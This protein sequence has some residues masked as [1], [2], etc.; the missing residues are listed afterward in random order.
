VIVAALDEFREATRAW[1]AAN[2]PEGAR[3][4]GQ[5]PTGSTKIRIEND[6]R[7]WLE[8]AEEGWTA[9]NW[10]KAQAAV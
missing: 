1:L 6:V 5:T 7:L 2:C 3:G 10:P 4:P 9:P 8:R